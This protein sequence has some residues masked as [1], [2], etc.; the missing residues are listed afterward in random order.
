MH[1]AELPFNTI[2]SFS[3][4]M[5]FFD[6]IANTIKGNLEELEFR[7]KDFLN[8]DDEEK[9]EEQNLAK[10]HRFDSF[11]PVRDGVQ[12]KYFVDGKDYLWLVH[13]VSLI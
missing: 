3:S 9:R 6:D 5:S 12:V 2:P 8:I 11:A 1:E 4:S 10:R 13:N 7:A